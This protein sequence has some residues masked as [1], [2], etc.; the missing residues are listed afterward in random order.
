M[1]SS[2]RPGS[3][4]P[5]GLANKYLALLIGHQ[6]EIL[7][8]PVIGLEGLLIGFDAYSL[9]ILDEDD[10]QLLVFKG[11][12]IGIRAVDDGPFTADELRDWGI[13]C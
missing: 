2:K 13:E 10:R 1:G 3:T 6:V 4:G 12:G 8:G 9:I 7:G 11:P 5:N